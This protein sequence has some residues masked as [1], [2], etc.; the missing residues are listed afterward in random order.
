[1]IRVLFRLTLLVMAGIAG[2]ALWQKYQFGLDAL[3][4]IDPVPE[5]R[6]M[7]AED[8]YADAASYLEFFI[9]YSPMGDDAEVQQLFQDVQEHRSSWSYRLR[10][11]GEGVLH[12]TSDETMGMFAGGPVIFL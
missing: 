9:E 11:I 7:V 1:M 5:A 10:K 2:A 12:G 8:R 3:K 6:K 4:A